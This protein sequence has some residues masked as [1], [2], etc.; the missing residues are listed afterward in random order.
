MQTYE[1]IFSTRAKDQIDALEDYLAHAA[2]PAISAR[3]VDGLIDYCDSL[4]HFPYRGMQR[5]DIRPG[6]RL[7]HYKNRT[8]IAF[9]I[10]IDAVHI[11]GVFHGGQDYETILTTDNH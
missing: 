11:L 2:S 4:S 1:V 7:T 5:P 6:L 9:R 8:V 3:Y 10:G